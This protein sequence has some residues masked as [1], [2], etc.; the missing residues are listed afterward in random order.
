MSLISTSN[1]QLDYNRLQRN[2]FCFNLLETRR[3]P[4]TLGNLSAPVFS[5]G[6]GQDL[7]LSPPK[8]TQEGMAMYFLPLS[9]YFLQCEL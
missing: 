1:V 2:V 6:S 8:H 7:V 4:Q 5:D 3:N 9:L